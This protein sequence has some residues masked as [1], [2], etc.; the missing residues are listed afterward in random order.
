MVPR[1]RW[2]FLTNHAIVLFEVW[3]NPDITV[4]QIAEL[5][6]ITERAAHRILASLVAEG[7]LGRNRIGRRN[8]Y[9]VSPEARLRHPQLA[10]LPI[11]QLLQVLSR[12]A[13]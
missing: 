6:Q 5:A 7:Y 1:G 3:R 12:E 2:T 10:H 13:R 11:E 9:V 4:R 8:H